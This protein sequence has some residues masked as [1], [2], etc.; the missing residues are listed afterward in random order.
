MLPMP[1]CLGSI[2]EETG[3]LDNHVHTGLIPGNLNRIPLGKNQD[4][5]PID[6]DVVLFVANLAL[7][8]SIIAVMLKQKSIG[9]S[10]RQVVDRDDL[11]ITVGISI[12]HCAKTQAADAPKSIDTNSN[13][14]SDV[15]PQ[16]KGNWWP[17]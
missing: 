8:V 12:E 7:E 4:L 9:M 11:D 15:P 6:D 16:E 2:R 10:I 1:G 17:E 3:G 5:F 13:C 14:H